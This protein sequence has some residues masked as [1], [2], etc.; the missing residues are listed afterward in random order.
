MNS[1]CALERKHLFVDLFILN[2]SFSC[3]FQAGE[4]YISKES[5]D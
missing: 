4:L 1:N 5:S 2:V 3:E